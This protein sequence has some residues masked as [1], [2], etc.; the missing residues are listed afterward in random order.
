[1]HAALPP[2]DV[3]AAQAEAILTGRVSDWSALGATA[4]PLR[5]VAGLSVAAASGVDRAVSDVDAARSVETDRD[6]IAAVPATVV[7]PTMRVIT[8]DG[9]DPLVDPTGYPLRTRGSTPPEPVT[10]TIVGDL[11]LARGVAASH[12]DGAGSVLSPMAPLLAAADVTV[13]NLESTLSRLGPPTQGDDSFGASPD[14]L[15]SLLAAGFDVLGLA[16]NHTG[17]YG[18]ES[19]FDTVRRVAATG[20]TPVGAGADLAEA[21]TPAVVERDGVRI[22]VLAFNA[23]GETPRATDEAP[24]ALELRMGSR[25]GPLDAGDLGRVTGLVRTLASTADIVIVLPH[26][27]TQYTHTPEPDQH[28]VARALADAGAD[29]VI[30]GHPHWVQGLERFDDTIVVHSLGNFVFDM[31]FMTQT[32]EGVL[33]QVTLWGGTVK[34]VTPVPYRMDDAFVPRVLEPADAGSILDPLW[35]SSGPPWSL[36]RG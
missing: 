4:R 33:L 31:D 22:G 25:T 24:G 3:T 21:S 9:V 14:V 2:L 28:T 16:N 32:M 15:G 20:I 35:A 26:W 7:G 36:G 23:I 27:G 18:T 1:M 29:L 13:G 34:A 19:L 30:G 6:V 8:V 11:M 10:L 17:D 12:P 5:V